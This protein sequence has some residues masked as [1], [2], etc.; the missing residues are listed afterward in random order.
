MI[1]RRRSRQVGD[2]D[3]MPSVCVYNLRRHIEV[4]RVLWTEHESSRSE[5]R[6]ESLALFMRMDSMEGEEILGKKEAKARYS[7]GRVLHYFDTASL[8]NVTCHLP[9]KCTSKFTC[10]G[11]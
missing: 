9:P 10:E 2:D 1:C 6:A 4:E 11:G 7:K 8:A 5:P 3:C